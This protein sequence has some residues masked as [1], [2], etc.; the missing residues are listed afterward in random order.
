M[1]YLFFDLECADGNY[2]ICEFGYVLT[3]ESFSVL[4]RKNILMDPEGEFRLS[5]RYGEPDLKLSYS[6]E[7]YRSHPPFPH[8]YDE[9]KRLLCSPDN[10]V[11]GYGV[12]NDV[13][14][15]AKDCRSYGLEFFDFHCRN[16][17]RYLGL[18]GL[19]KGK[20]VSLE[21]AYLTLLPEGEDF[22]EHR[23]EDD[24]Y[25][26]MKVLAAIVERTGRSVEELASLVPSS[27]IDS[28]SYMEEKRKRADE[29]Y[30]HKMRQQRMDKNRQVWKDE[31]LSTPK[32]KVGRGV[33][34]CNELFAEDDPFALFLDKV[35]REA[36]LP[37]LD[38]FHAEL[39]VALNESEKRT[40]SKA[41]A[42]KVNCLIVSLEEFLSL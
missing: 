10:L 39:C 30:Q 1:N 18:T 4:E 35:R 14:F 36:Y 9:I 34:C 15:L 29:A 33:Y 19:F 7:E 31:V 27:D 5:G 41:V 20:S 13:I 6:E 24:A 3:D 28:L 26:T 32:T 21:N 37:C 11:F 23:A 22:Q 16:V 38:F 12:N 8:Y 2:E 25:A 40:L 42:G 17:Q